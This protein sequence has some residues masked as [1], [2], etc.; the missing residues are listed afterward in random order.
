M[1]NVWKGLVVGGLTG[2][3]AGVVL[4]SLRG[5]SRTASH[6][7]RQVRD[8]APDATEW[9]HETGKQVGERLR[10]ADLPDQ[11]RQVAHEVATSDVAERLSETGSSLLSAAREAGDRSR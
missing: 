4:D 6:W 1:R 3:A 8:R 9:L 10:Q 2:V 11:V 5:A 7:G